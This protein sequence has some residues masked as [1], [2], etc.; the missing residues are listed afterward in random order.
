MADTTTP[1]TPSTKAPATSPTPT[2][3][4]A[5]LA[6][7]LAALAQSN[8]KITDMMEQQ[9]KYNQA[10]LRIAPRR[11]KSMPEY[12][13]ERRKK[14]GGDKFLPHLVFQNGRAVNPSGL[15]NE[16]IGK[17]DTLASGR[18]CDGV[19][20]VQRISD[21]I[22]GISSRIH[23]RYNNG[24]IEERMR[25]Y[26]RFP[27]FTVLVTAIADEMAARAKDEKGNPDPKSPYAPVVEKGMDPPEFDFSDDLK[28]IV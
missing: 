28:E 23:L 16:T 3:T 7:T 15:S 13:S 26:M 9:A 22:D 11:K 18:Y 12:L 14:R 6:Q 21:G 2:S 19:V 25:F 5:L 8:Q 1:T 10:A 4:E 17:L 27:S 20:D 24:T